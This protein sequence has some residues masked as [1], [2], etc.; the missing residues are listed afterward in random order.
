[1][2]WCFPHLWLLQPPL[3]NSQKPTCP[4]EPLAR[5]RQTDPDFDFYWNQF[6]QIRLVSIW[7]DTDLMPPVPLTRSRQKISSVHLCRHKL[8]R[9]EFDSILLE[10]IGPDLIWFVWIWFDFIW[11]EYLTWTCLRRG[12]ATLRSSPHMCLLSW[13]WWWCWFNQYIIYGDDDKYM[14]IMIIMMMMLVMLT[15][16]VHW[17]GEWKP[18]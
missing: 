3:Q 16:T 4:P 10:L 7:W 13:W 6:D 18:W 14:T 12:G 17:A 1:M 5:S 2:T 8:I 15:L 9:I 11:V